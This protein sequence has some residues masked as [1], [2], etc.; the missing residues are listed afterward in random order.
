M[1]INQLDS[2]GYYVV[3]F[4][5]G[6]SGEA[7]PQHWTSDLVGDGYFKAQYTNASRDEKTGEMQGGEWVEV[8]IP[9]AI[10]YVTPA[11]AEFKVLM[12]AATLAIAPLQDAVDLQD[13][14][15]DEA[16]LLKK[17]KRYRMALNRLDLSA[18]PDIDWPE[19]PA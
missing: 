9:P 5:V 13:V 7:L 3:D 16:E 19:T 2:Q 12:Q 1:K 10:D 14:T 11:T 15:E 8:G 17:W 6:V 18:A 4:I